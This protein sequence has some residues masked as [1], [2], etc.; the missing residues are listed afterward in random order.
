MWTEIYGA[1]RE[2][3]RAGHGYW[4][5]ITRCRRHRAKILPKLKTAAR[6]LLRPQQAR[7][8]TGP[9]S[10]VRGDNEMLQFGGS[11]SD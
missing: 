7:A 4:G 6:R 11:L 1:R 9:N 5:G 10:S 8:G 2:I 3:W